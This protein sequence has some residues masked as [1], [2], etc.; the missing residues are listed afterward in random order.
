MPFRKPEDHR[1]DNQVGI[2][3]QSIRVLNKCQTPQRPQM[4]LKTSLK[5]TQCIQHVLARNPLPAV[6]AMESSLGGPNT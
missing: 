4:M 3:T 2:T 6:L 5:G 1:G